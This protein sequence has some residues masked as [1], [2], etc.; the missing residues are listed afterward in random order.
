M[1]FRRASSELPRLVFSDIMVPHQGP[2]AQA[3]E[4]ALRMVEAGVDAVGIHLQ[5]DARR[6]N[7][8]L[9]EDDYLG[10][11]ARF[12]IVEMGRRCSRPRASRRARCLS[13]VS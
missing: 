2:A 1:V 8:K 4:V 10:D 6:A 13:A 7:P 5:S 3:G 9:I 12:D 11:V